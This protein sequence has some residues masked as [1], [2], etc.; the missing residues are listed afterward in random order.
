MRAQ[1][2]GVAAKHNHTDDLKDSCRL[3]GMPS[4][5]RPS[6]SECLESRKDIDDD[7]PVHDLT[8]LFVHLSERQK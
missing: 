8:I 6:S 3:R 2:L 7:K 1:F 4:P 5:L